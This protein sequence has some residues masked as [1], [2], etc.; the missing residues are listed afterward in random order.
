[1]NGHFVRLHQNARGAT[2]QAQNSHHRAS[3]WISQQ[4]PTAFGQIGQHGHNHNISQAGIFQQLARQKFNVRRY[5]QE[6]GTQ[7]S[8]LPPGGAL[9]TQFGHGTA[10]GFSIQ[11]HGLHIVVSFSK[12][13]GTIVHQR[14]AL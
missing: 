8:Q 2:G 11:R 13:L 6:A 4:V 1:M 7:P 5:H 12:C 9:V 14:V 10:K 3:Q